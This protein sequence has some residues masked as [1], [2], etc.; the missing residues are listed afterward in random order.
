MTVCNL[1]TERQSPYTFY[2]SRT[3]TQHLLCEV[4]GPQKRSTISRDS[5][6][7]IG[8]QTPCCNTN[9]MFTNPKTKNMFWTVLGLNSFM[10]YAHLT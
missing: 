5:K 9:P 10:T 8:R 4:E 6:G 7:N 2:N 1:D 3:H